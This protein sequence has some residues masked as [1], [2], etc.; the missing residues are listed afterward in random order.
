MS[1]LEKFVNHKKH[2]VW[3]RLAEELGGEIQENLVFRNRMYSN[4]KHWVSAL[5][6]F[7][8]P[9]YRYGGY[10]TRLH[11]PVNLSE[12]FDFN[13]SPATLLLK[14]QDK[15]KSNIILTGDENFDK[16]M[17]IK[18]SNHSVFPQLITSELMHLVWDLQ[19]MEIDFHKEM[20]YQGIAILN[21][22][23]DGRVTD[24][25]E[26]K[27]MYSLMYMLLDNLSAAKIIDS[28]HTQPSGT[29]ILNA[30]LW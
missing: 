19:K 28:N 2:E 9:G 14:F 3:L 7:E 20:H 24:Y 15:T 22:K 26:L 10:Q 5:D 13:I 27:Q 17:V 21:I 16:K 1:F 30:I 29:E 12:D 18:M 6:M 23:K 8:K 25:T 11:I 4:Y